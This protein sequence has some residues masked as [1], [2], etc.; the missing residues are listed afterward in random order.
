MALVAALAGFP[1]GGLGRALPGDGAIASVAAEARPSAAPSEE[2]PGL[3]AVN[4]EAP[5]PPLKGDFGQAALEEALR[6]AELESREV[7]EGGQTG[8]AGWSAGDWLSVAAFLAALAL[9]AWATR[10]F[11]RGPLFGG[12]RGRE[13]VLLDRMAIGRQST[14]LVIRL[15][16]R[17]YWVADHPRGVTLLAP[18]DAEGP[19]PPAGAKPGA[20]GGPGQPPQGHAVLP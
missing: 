6:R 19:A 14:L 2:E 9:M 17:D 12:G 8:A 10:A 16:G 5:A 11:R 13:M 7:G 3:D 1:F 18:L 15:R 4:M 20:D